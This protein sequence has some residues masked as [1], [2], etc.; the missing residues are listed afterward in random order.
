M[1]WYGEVWCDM[2]WYAVV[3]CGVVWCALLLYEI[4]KATIGVP[5]T[6]LVLTTGVATGM[7]VMAPDIM[8]ACIFSDLFD[9]S[10]SYEVSDP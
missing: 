8:G 1:V 2:V 5:A 3:W 6:L 7:G 4:W 9:F 10:N